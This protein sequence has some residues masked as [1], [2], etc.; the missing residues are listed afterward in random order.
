MKTKLLCLFLVLLCAYESR[1]GWTPLTTGIS[2]HLNGVVI[3]DS[4]GVV[5]SREGLYYTHN[6]YGGPA[7]WHKLTLTGYTA[8]SIVL[9]H[10]RFNHCYM[11]PGGTAVYACG[12]DT[13]AH[14]AIVLTL[15]PSTMS[16][17]IP[18]TGAVGSALNHIA[19]NGYFGEYEMVGNKGLAVAI[20]TQGAEELNTHIRADLVSISYV[21]SRFAMVS[22][23]TLYTGNYS[24]P[25]IPPTLQSQALNSVGA[26]YRDVCVTNSTQGFAVGN[27]EV[28][29]LQ[30]TATELREYDFG[31]LN[32]RCVYQHAFRIYV[33]T[34]HGIFVSDA[35]MS[36]L[37]YQ[38]SSQLYHINSMWAKDNTQMYACGDNGTLLVL[39]GVGES[40]PVANIHM[41][42]GCANAS[43]VLNASVGTSTL[44]RWYI[45]DSLASYQCQ[46]ATFNF[47]NPGLDTIRLLVTNDSLYSDTS[48]Q[49]IQIVPVP[50]VTLPHTMSKPFICHK[51]PEVITLD[52]S[53]SGVLYVM[54]RYGTIQTYG[55]VSGTG[56]TVAL[57]SDSLTT[58][59]YYYLRASSTVVQCSARFRDTLRIG[60]ERTQ[61]DFHD[62]YVNASL[63]TAAPFYQH[64][65]DSQHYQWSFSPAPVAQGGVADSIATAT[66]TTPGTVQ[67]RLICSSDH[68]CTDTLTRPATT[69][70]T[71]TGQNDDCWQLLASGP[72]LTWSGQAVPNTAGSCPLQDGGF[73]VSGEFNQGSLPSYYGSAAA[74]SRPAQGGYCARYTSK[75]SLSW[76]VYSQNIFATVS[77]A[78]SSAAEDHDGNIYITG[79]GTYLKDNTGDSIVLLRNYQTGFL[80]KLDPQ[81]RLIWR[82]SIGDNYPVSF[83]GVSIDHDNNLIVGIGSQYPTLRKA[84]YLNGVVVDTLRD[85]K[86]TMLKLTPN[87]QILW[88]IGVKIDAT[89]YAGYGLPQCD[90]ANNVYLAGYYEYGITFYSAGDTVGSYMPGHRDYGSSGFMAK[91]DK[92][93]QL[94]WKT[95]TITIGDTITANV[96]MAMTTDSSGNMYLTGN[97]DIRPGRV[98]VFENTDGTIRTNTGGKYY[99]AK[100]NNRGQCQWLQTIRGGVNATAEA[101]IWQSGNEV[102][103]IGRLALLAPDTTYAFTSHDG[104]DLSPHFTPFLRYL[105]SYDTAGNIRRLTG[106][107]Y[108]QNNTVPGNGANNLFRSGGSY[109]FSQN[110]LNQGAYSN[111]GMAIPPTNGY[112]GLITKFNPSCGLIYYT[113]SSDITAYVCPGGSYWFHGHLL[114]QTGTYVDT[115]AGA[116]AGGLDSIVT[117]RLITSSHLTT[118]L[119]DSACAG[120]A[121]QYHG[122]AVIAPGT[123]TDTFT[124]AAGC[125]SLVVLHLSSRHTAPITWV[126]ADTEVVIFCGQLL[127]PPGIRHAQ[128]AGGHY[129][130]IYVSG[131]SIFPSGTA[132]YHLPAGDSLFYIRYT[133]TEPGGCPATLTKAFHLSYQC[134]G[135]AA[136]DEGAAIQLYPDPNRGTFTLCKAD[137]SPAT[138]SIYD[139]MG[140]L[141]AQGTMLSA[142]QSVHLPDAG[143]GIYM[144]VL[145]SGTGTG[146]VKFAVER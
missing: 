29:W 110:Y 93:G 142:R 140:R 43:Q 7:A 68:G 76:V 27:T 77:P 22:R 15:D 134:A 20:G 40:K 73:M 98:Q 44:C 122:R 41:T 69:Y 104:Y 67:V 79:Y 63:G 95:R 64:C 62:G 5:T 94:Q 88:G 36:D 100:V 131:D 117:L 13:V 114:T 80:V 128:P 141:M 35:A 92:N 130:G 12:E 125:D 56:G 146:S 89:N 111:F 78:I 21:Y 126:Q 123:Y 97:N 139:V 11:V 61:A 86:S 54:A 113:H 51:E 19:Y 87:G 107:G 42:G 120:T 6:A 102:S 84:I 58:G 90:A 74:L 38:P 136:S 55:Q 138:Y 9:S 17:Q 132:G 133:Y 145:H 72:D 14:K 8:D 60:L 70:V 99:V 96:I 28:G 10:T 137:A 109:L 118:D 24:N 53:Q 45:N 75:G 115:L 121:Y 46:N 37:E 3:V 119:Y 66:Y 85:A 135:I 23:D 71:E 32:G 30:S 16:Y 31:P 129:D 18:Y 25:M 81:G 4:T 116:A 52:S 108:N 65:T 33:G 143:V 47:R 127:P 82:L 101:G 103:V 124:A 59:G 1:A 91:F 144:L 26:T 57:I 83:G 50:S 49:V 112:D 39:R 2:S 48:T 106:D 105:A 34:D